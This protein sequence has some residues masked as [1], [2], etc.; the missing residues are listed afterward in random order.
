MS[1]THLAIRYAEALYE[2]AEENG[3]L[4]A[5]TAD[6]EFIEN[7]LSETPEIKNY[8]RLKRSGG[9]Q[10]REFI[11]IAFSPYVSEFTENMLITAAANGRLAAIPLMP[12]A[13]AK[14]GEKKSGIIKLVLETAHP[15]SDELIEIVK[16]RMSKRTDKK[17]EI[18]KKLS[19]DLLGG[20]RIWYE[21]RL[22]DSSVTGRLT[23]MRRLLD[24]F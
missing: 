3:A 6:M 20:F 15:P 13:F 17:I 14:I 1:G 19:P 8:C 21:G 4:A 7:L 11:E 16:R 2:V 10:E 23:R 5:A 24:T 22:I 18:E 12:Q 9:R